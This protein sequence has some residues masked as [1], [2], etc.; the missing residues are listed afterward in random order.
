[1]V[2]IQLGNVIA[3]LQKPHRYSLKYK[4]ILK[5]YNLKVQ[6]QTYPV[7]S[8]TELFSQ[9]RSSE[10]ANQSFDQRSMSIYISVRSADMKFG[11]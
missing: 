10:L 6:Q 9:Q 11:T 1:M 5:F 3:L 7:T 2:E 8:H 4:I